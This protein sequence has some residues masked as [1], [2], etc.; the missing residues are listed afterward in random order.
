MVAI[1]VDFQ[2]IFGLNL[3]TMETSTQIVSKYSFNYI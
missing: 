1:D 2:N 3:V